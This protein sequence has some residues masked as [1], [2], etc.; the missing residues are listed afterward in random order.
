MARNYID[1][2]GIYYEYRTAGQ[3]IIIQKSKVKIQKVCFTQRRKGNAKT[4]S[5]VFLC[6]FAP[7][8]RLC[9]KQTFEF[10]QSFTN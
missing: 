5:E 10:N 2:C 7:P 9:V 4:P 8:L 3:A 6:V 1:G